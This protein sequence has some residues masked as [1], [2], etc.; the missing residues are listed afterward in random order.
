MGIQIHINNMASDPLYFLC[1][2]YILNIAVFLNTTDVTGTSSLVT[3]TDSTANTDFP[4]VFNNESNTHHKP[5]KVFVGKTNI[6]PSSI[7]FL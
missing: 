2:Q 7:I 4:V 6:Q 5:Y 3:V 1:T